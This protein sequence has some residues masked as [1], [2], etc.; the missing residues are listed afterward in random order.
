MTMDVEAKAKE[1]AV[2]CPGGAGL[3]RRLGG[4]LLIV[5][6]MNDPRTRKTE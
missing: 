2:A 6:F 5:L 3:M 4:W 1:L